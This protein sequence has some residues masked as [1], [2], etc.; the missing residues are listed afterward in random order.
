[1]DLLDDYDHQRLE[2]PEEGSREVF[3]ITYNEARK[4]IDEL[5]R[6]TKFEGL[7]GR[8]KYDSFKG[9]LENIYQ[10]FGGED[11]YPATEEK[12]AHLLYFVVKNHLFSDG[13]KRIA[14]FLFVWFMDRNKILYTQTGY[15]V[16]PD[17]A[18]VALTLLIAESHPGDKEMMIKV[19]VNLISRH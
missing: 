15:K 7:F 11:L 19:I 13:N 8:E 3:Q 16:I 14:A 6:Q 10:T 18:L 4:A 2:V 17:N 12:A 5:G 1:M 9:S